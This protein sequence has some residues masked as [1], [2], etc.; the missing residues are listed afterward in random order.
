MST[1][2]VPHVIP[3][4]SSRE[5]TPVPTV[6]E[7]RSIFDDHVREKSTLK[8]L[9]IFAVPT[10]IYV[11]AMVGFLRSSGWPL[12][13]MFAG[14][15]GLCIDMLFVVGHDGCSRASRHCLG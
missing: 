15:I 1:I 11:A 5:A 9:I 13:L 4:R 3:S 6:K 7:V 10:A 2:D 8:G 14:L 12:K